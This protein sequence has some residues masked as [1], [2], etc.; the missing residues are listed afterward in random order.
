M[1]NQEINRLIAE[2]VMGY[3]LVYNEKF[4]LNGWKMGE[5][6][7]AGSFIP[8]ASIEDAWKVVEKLREDQ[9]KMDIVCQPENYVVYVSSA[10]NESLEIKSKTA[11]EA[12]CLAALKAV[13]YEME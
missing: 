7:W 5:K 4:E 10:N 13:G 11:P 9:I 3:E 12:I 2:K 8:S 1:D 6:S